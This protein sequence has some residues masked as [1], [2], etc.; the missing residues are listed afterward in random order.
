MIV[1]WYE[2]RKVALTWTKLLLEE[3]KLLVPYSDQPHHTQGSFTDCGK[4]TQKSAPKHPY[5]S[6]LFSQAVSCLFVCLFRVFFWFDFIV[7]VFCLNV[8]YHIYLC[9]ISFYQ[10]QNITIVFWNLFFKF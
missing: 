4:S 8:G 9:S 6:V 7:C 5:S 3:P 10:F 2:P 1:M